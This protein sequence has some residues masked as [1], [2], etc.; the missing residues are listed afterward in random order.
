[1]CGYNYLYMTPEVFIFIGQSGAGKGTQAA[2]LKAALERSDPQTGVIDLEIGAVFRKLIKTDG[3]TA[4][5]TKALM[6]EGTLPPPFLGIHA[7]THLL[8]EKY[9]GKSNLIIDGTPRVPDEVPILIT[10]AKFY[11]WEPHV[12]FIDVSDE[13]AYEKTKGRGREDDKDERDIWGRIQWFHQSVI[14]TI[15]LLKAAPNMKFHSVHGE[16]TIENV[17]KDICHELGIQP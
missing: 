9:D 17:H 4:Q 1:V 10:A 12:I 11:G 14:P 7:W 3:Y 5:K 13:W 6:D 16:Q 8:I 2:L 15:E